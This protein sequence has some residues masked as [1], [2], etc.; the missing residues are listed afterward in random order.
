MLSQLSAMK[1]TPTGWLL[2]LQLTNCK[3]CNFIYD[4]TSTYLRK[5]KKNKLHPCRLSSFL[6]HLSHMDMIFSAIQ[7]N[8]HYIS[9]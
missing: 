2:K 1:A 3:Y 5:K 7:R 4:I 6:K 8:V 9:S